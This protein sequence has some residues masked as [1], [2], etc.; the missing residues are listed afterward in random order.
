VVGSKHYVKILDWLEPYTLRAGG[1]GPDWAK[2]L[3]DDITDRGMGVTC[4]PLPPNESGSLIALCGETFFC[5]AGV[6]KDRKDSLFVSRVE[7]AARHLPDRPPTHY[8]AEFALVRQSALPAKVLD[9]VTNIFALLDAKAKTLLDSPVVPARKLL[10]WLRSAP[11]ETLRAWSPRS[12]ATQ[13]PEKQEFLAAVRAVWARHRL[14]RLQR[15]SGITDKEAGILAGHITP[16]QLG[17]W[18]RNG[19]LRAFGVPLLNAFVHAKRVDASGLHALIRDMATLPLGTELSAMIWGEMLSG[20]S[21]ADLRRELHDVAT[22]LDVLRQDAKLDAAWERALIRAM[23]EISSRHSDAGLQ[24]VLD[25]AA[26]DHAPLSVITQWARRLELGEAPLPAPAI[27]GASLAASSAAANPAVVTPTPEF[28]LGTDAVAPPRAGP[29]PMEFDRWVLRLRLPET[30][31]LEPVRQSAGDACRDLLAITQGPLDLASLIRFSHVAARLEGVLAQWRK[32]VPEASELE[33]D[34]AEAQ[35]A[36]NSARSVLGDKAGDLLE[37]R[38]TPEDL[39][40]VVGLLKDPDLLN[41]VPEWIWRSGDAEGEQE[42]DSREREPAVELDKEA[43]L[44]ARPLIRRRVSTVV[45][46]CRD[47]HDLLKRALP[48]LP[49]PPSHEDVEQYLQT[50]LRDLQSIGHLLGRYTPETVTWVETILLEGSE[51]ATM[52]AG[53]Q[54]LERL[55]E[56]LSPEASERVMA[57]LRQTRGAEEA[58]EL[59]LLFE[60]A[61]EAIAENFGS[62][63][64]ATFE[65]ISRWIERNKDRVAQE[66]GQAPAV[67]ILSF[68]HNLVGHPP[69][70]APLRFHLPDGQPFGYL[71]APFLVRSDRPRELHIRLEIDAAW[72]EREGWPPEWD[73]PEPKELRIAARD[74]RRHVGEEGFVYSFKLVVPTRKPSSRIAVSLRGID[75]VTQ[76]VVVPVE[77]YVWDDVVADAEPITLNWPDVIDPQ[78]VVEHPVGPQKHVPTIKGRMAGGSSFAVLA[79]RRFGK[80]TLLSHLGHVGHAENLGVVGP[81]S[82]LDYR[83]PAFDYQ[84]FWDAIGDACQRLVG[85]TIDRRLEKEL[86]AAEAFDHVRHAAR[87]KGFQAV[88]ILVDEAQAFFPRSGGDQLGDRVKSLIEQSWGRSDEKAKVPVS[89][90]LVGLPSLRERAGA[91]LMGL[92]RPLED[93][94][95]DEAVLNRLILKF[96]RGQLFTTREARARLAQRSRNVFVVKTLLERLVQT[97]NSEGRCWVSFDDILTVEAALRRELELG[98]AST[99]ADYVRDVLNDAETINEWAPNAALPV[100]LA[101]AV[102]RQRGARLDGDPFDRCARILEEWCTQVE[103]EDFGRPTYTRERFRDHIV[104]LRDRGVFENGAFKSELLEAW[105]VGLTRAGFPSDEVTR[106]ALLSGAMMRVRV[107]EPLDPLA[108]EGAQATIQTHQADGGLRLA[109]RR[110]KLADEEQRK[111]FLQTAEALAKLKQRIHLREAGS[112]YVFALHEVGLAFRDDSTAVMI[113]R[114]IEGSDLEDR[115]GRLSAGVVSDIGR[116]LAMAVGLLHGLG[117]LHRDIRPK[118]V[119]LADE[120]GVD[121]GIRPVLIDFGLARLEGREMRTQLGHSYSAPEVQGQ[122]PRWSRA[123]DIFALGALLRALLSTKDPQRQLVMDATLSTQDGEATRRPTAEQLATTLQELVRR[124]DIEHK[125]AGAW[126]RV[127]ELAADDSSKPWFRPILEKFRARFEGLTLGLYPDSY[128]RCAELADFTNQVLEANQPRRLSLAQVKDWNAE[129]QDALARP[130]VSL[131]HSLRIYRSHG[132][133]TLRAKVRRFNITSDSDLAERTIEGM[134]LI[135]KYLNTEA[136]PALAREFA[137]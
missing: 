71:T 33:N 72:K 17:P 128:E 36:F 87:R 95:I 60:R 3:F 53:A 108:I 9:P 27:S 24:D 82:C 16:K 66:A 55:T 86:P 133:V 67:S 110:V 117:V 119:I 21:P 135:G 112:E 124:L 12:V 15:D 109:V 64:D 18:E 30:E 77:R 48:R 25:E 98:A 47:C 120:Q 101:L 80:T 106:Q 10:E 37:R 94:E 103:T 137:R 23:S 84:A 32:V 105:L 63:K 115:V 136:L 69:R 116:R 19:L 122:Q 91:N 46:A 52:L 2:S 83:E 57:A 99:V 28:T 45:A 127:L 22:G 6:D 100:A 93:S 104:T 126:D 134:A 75:V 90:A 130:S 111:R 85:S 96:T 56:Q 39:A 76:R 5:M 132:S 43:A 14:D 1:G 50:R 35:A 42:P 92:L 88:V 97:A 8:A 129:T 131:L 51:P 61:A 73:V 59:I 49:P 78:S 34:I 44:L 20:L 118:N 102:A 107:P 114:W 89:L 123:A 58:R 4:Y 40:E 70:R 26:Y 113:Y 125:R 41:L 121:G 65:Q 68:E 31:S 62:A 74:W 11:V 54:S 81:I 29:Q 79:P 38:I 7:S 13:L